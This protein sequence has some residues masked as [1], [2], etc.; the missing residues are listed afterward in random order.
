MKRRYIISDRIGKT[1]HFFAL[2]DLLNNIYLAREIKNTKNIPYLSDIL[3]ESQLGR[4][5]QYKLYEWKTK[6]K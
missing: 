4:L 6:N 3:Y 5:L 2:K 1:H